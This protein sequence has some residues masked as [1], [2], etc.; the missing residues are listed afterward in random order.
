MSDARVHRVDADDPRVP[1]RGAAALDFSRYRARRLRTRLLELLDALAGA[2]ERRDPGGVWE[3]LDETDACRSLP[4]AVREEALLIA[5]MP[6][7]SMR[8]PVR[9]YRYYHML[10]QLGDEPGEMSG[11]P[12]QLRIALEIEGDALPDDEA[13]PASGLADDGPNVEGPNVH[14]P[15]VD[16]SGRRGSGFR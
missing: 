2:I 1:G 16:G 9:L 5:G 8:A 3:V 13:S 15:N 4:P 14:G 6:P 10:Q 12:D 11:D 7:T